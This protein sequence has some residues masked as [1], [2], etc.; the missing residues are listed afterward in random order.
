MPNQI[1]TWNPERDCWETG[2]EDIFGHSDVYSE[3]WPTSGMT[4]NGVAYALPT[5]APPTTD[6][7]SSSS[8]PAKTFRTPAAAEAEG[9]PR[10]RNRPGATMRLSDQVREEMEDGNLRV[11]KTPTSQLAVNGGSQHPDKRRAGGHGPTLA[12]EVEHLLPTPR[13]TRGGSSTETVAMLPTPTAMDAHSSGGSTPS[14][15]TL[16]DAAVR[17]RMGTIPNPRHE[18]TGAPTPPPSTDGSPSWEDVP[19]PLPSSPNEE[20]TDS[21]PVSRSS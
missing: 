7:A 6:S 10:D 4:R 17:S 15:V 16:T 18:P 3:T 11:L 20:N 12:D 13:A 2:V 9:G 21:P 8:P 19:L 14:N 1:A 5:W